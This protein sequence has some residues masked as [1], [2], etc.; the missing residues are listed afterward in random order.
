MNE[1]KI[2]T[3]ADNVIWRVT[4]IKDDF[5]QITRLLLVQHSLDADAQAH[6]HT[7]NFANHAPYHGPSI[8][9]DL[10]INQ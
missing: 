1:K 7:H 9:F 6:T 8:S 3:K 10:N 2:N 5:P 4:Q